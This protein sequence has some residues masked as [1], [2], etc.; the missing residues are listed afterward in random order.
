MKLEHIKSGVAEA[1]S[2]LMGIQVTVGQMGTSDAR[3]ASAWPS[4]PSGYGEWPW[5]EWVHQ[6]RHDK[7]MHFMHM[8][9]AGTSVSSRSIF[10][11]FCL[12]MPKEKDYIS[13]KFVASDLRGGAWSG[14]V[15]SS[16]FLGIRLAKEESPS[17]VNQLWIVDPAPGLVP[18]YEAYAQPA[19]YLVKGRV[20]EKSVVQR[21]EF[22]FA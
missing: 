20:M 3:A 5:E 21:I 16:F 19:G 2:A 11:A 7:S 1:A 13:L 8:S 4:H 18:T 17:P 6:Y 14:K 9:I 10:A 15:L 22:K 12:K